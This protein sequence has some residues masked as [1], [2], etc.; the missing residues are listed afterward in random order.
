LALIEVS[1]ALTIGEDLFDTGSLLS[2]LT[3]L[4]HAVQSVENTSALI[5]PSHII[6]LVSKMVDSIAKSTAHSTAPIPQ[7]KETCV[8][9]QDLET[10]NMFGTMQS[11]QERL[12]IMTGHYMAWKWIMDTCEYFSQPSVFS[13][14]AICQ[15]SWVAAIARVL[16]STLG[17]TSRVMTIVP[18][19]FSTELSTDPLTFTL[20]VMRNSFSDVNARQRAVYNSL[21]SMLPQMLGLPSRPYPFA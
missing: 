4:Q 18:A 8:G 19:N 21:L 16:S 12:H 14:A 6:S 7:V 1:S 5:S 11:S 17:V 13:S 10:A 9:L 20:L 3:K 15:E 2:E